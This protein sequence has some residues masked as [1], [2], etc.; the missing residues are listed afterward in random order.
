[1]AIGSVPAG[2]A[3]CL[4]DVRLLAAEYDLTIDPPDATLNEPKALSPAL[5]ESGGIIE[6]PPTGDAAV[7]EPPGTVDPE[8]ETVPELQPEEDQSVPP[9]AGEPPG[10][11]LAILQTI[12]TSAR[13]QAIVGDEE[14]CLARLE[15]ARK[16]LGETD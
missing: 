11:E 16:V 9:G 4:E 14:G 8:M 7:I 15:E 13:Q 5:E 3:T 1:M 2:A 12:L 6:P 10:S